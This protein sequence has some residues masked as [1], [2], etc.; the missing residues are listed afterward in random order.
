MTQHPDIVNWNPE[1]A[2][3]PLRETRPGSTAF[4]LASL[5][6]PLLKL[7][8]FIYQSEGMTNSYLIKTSEGDVLVCPG[9][10]VEGE[11][12][13]QKFAQVSS[14]PLR[15]VILTQGHVDNV[16]GLPAFAGPGVEVIAHRDSPNCQIDDE[17]IKGFRDIRNPRFFPQ[18]LSSLAEA[19]R[20]AMKRGMETA[21]QRAE[22]TVLID[23]EAT[24]RFTLGGVRFE[25]IAIPGGETLDSLLVWLPDQRIV[26]TGNCLG[27]L[28]P[29]MPNLH[30][31]RGD[32]PRPVLPYIGTY[33]KLLSLGAELLITGHFEPVAGAQLVHDELKRLRDA[34][35]YVHDETVKGMNTGK[36]LYALMREIKLPEALKVGEDYGTVM[37]AVQAIWYGYAGWF[38]FKSTT[39]IYPVPVRDVYAEIADVAGPAALAARARKLLADG[40]SLD[41]IH[42][43]EI[44]LAKVPRLAEALQV[45]LEA[46]ERLLA[47]SSP[48]NRWFLFWLQGE[49]DQTRAR[50][51]QGAAA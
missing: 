42:L 11:I 28:F 39:E 24:H 31:I 23:K 25:I 5:S 40:R 27:P 14:G 12:H 17:R 21:H 9:L 50:L 4:R 33:D 37:W 44:A 46:H 20:E 19:D 30:T 36:E 49:I 13:R 45:Y 2:D 35:Q 43:S 47:E 1:P 15:Y 18:V 6:S 8:D 32:K 29:H 3:G 22:A 26:F 10:V 7:N 34:V 16:G 51:A 41:A 48:K 38:L